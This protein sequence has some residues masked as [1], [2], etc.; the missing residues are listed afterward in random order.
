[1][2][3]VGFWSSQLQLGYGT[4][5]RANGYPLRAILF[6]VMDSTPLVFIVT[7]EKAQH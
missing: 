7:S 6:G 4:L 3:N 2:D 5:V 1:M